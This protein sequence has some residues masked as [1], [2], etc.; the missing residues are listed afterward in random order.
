MATMTGVHALPPEV[1][2][3]ATSPAGM[4]ATASP[5]RRPEATVP[6]PAQA[7]MVLTGHGVEMPPTEA[8]LLRAT[9]HSVLGAGLGA[10]WIWRKPAAR[11]PLASS[12]TAASQASPT[13]CPGGKATSARSP[14][15]EIRARKVDASADRNSTDQVQVLQ[16]RSASEKWT[17]AVTTSSAAKRAPF[18]PGLSQVTTGGRRSRS[19]R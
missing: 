15:P 6:G 8:G 19:G 13:D 16:G 3:Q 9:I 11:F 5:P 1:V 10:I 17:A 2:D 7:L 18:C 4:R 14:S 12:T